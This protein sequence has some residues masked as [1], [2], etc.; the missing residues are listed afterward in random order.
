M[1]VLV[2]TAVL[3]FAAGRPHP[4]RDPCRVALERVRDG[5]L[6]GVTS[7]EVVQEVLHRFTGTSRHAD[8]VRLARGA[9]RLFAPVLAVDHTVARRTVALAERYGEFRARDLVHVATC[10]VH[11]I[12]TILSPDTDFD[13][14][15]EVARLDPT[16]LG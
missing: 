16:A 14:I 5:S 2:D 13:V 7:A 6:A 4:L 11:G 12:D 15:D 8:G 10:L 9:L 3:M 1:T